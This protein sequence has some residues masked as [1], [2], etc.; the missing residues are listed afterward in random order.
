[1]RSSTQVWQTHTVQRELA[2]DILRT[3]GMVRLQAAGSSMLPTVWP[4]DILV[5]APV[6]GP[7]VQQGDIVAFSRG[8][9]FVAHRVATTW[10]PSEP[11]VQTRG[12]ALLEIDPPVSGGDIMGKV[13]LILRNG[14]CIEPHRSLRLRE[15]VL[16]GLFRQSSFAVR[17]AVKLCETLNFAVRA[18]SNNRA[19]PCES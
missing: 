8:G 10:T 17:I 7:D 6:T 15:R 5:V 4:G 11:A 16:A 1:M 14:R 2:A 19:V 18:D 12:D 13:V 3:S 9:R